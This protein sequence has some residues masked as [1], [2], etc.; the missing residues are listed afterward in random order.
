[1]PCPRHVLR[2][3]ALLTA[4][5]IACCCCRQTGL[6]KVLEERINRI[7]LEF[8]E[9]EARIKRVPLEKIDPVP[10]LTLRVMATRF[11]SAC[12]TS[13]SCLLNCCAAMKTV[14]SLPANHLRL[15][16]DKDYFVSPLMRER[17]RTQGYPD[18]FPQRSKTLLLFQV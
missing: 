7:V 5:L 12:H 9:D 16:S 17:Y 15:H 10:R 8:R 1:V 2:Y 3:D 13:E 11:V 14:G 4:L 18:A 6:S